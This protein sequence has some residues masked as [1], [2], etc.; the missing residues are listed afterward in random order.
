MDDADFMHIALGLAEKGRGFTSPNPMVGAVVVSDNRIVG[1]G[2]HQ[3]AGGPHAEIN[4]LA[5]AAE[6]ARGATLYVTL[7]PCNHT[8]R[9]GPC[10]AKIISAGIRKVVVAMQDLNPDVCGGGIA[11]LRSHGIEVV[12]GVGEPA[13]RRLN[14]SFVKFITT[15]RPFVIVKCAAT[16]DGR[17]ATHTGDSKWVSGPQARAYVHRLRHSTDA[18]MVGVDTIKADDPQLTARLADGQGKDPQRI[19]LDTHLSI[20]LEA[21]V[22]SSTS[23][24][25]TY[26]VCQQGIDPARRGAVEKKGARVIECELQQGRIDLARLMERL[27]AMQITSLLIE[28]GG[29]VIGSALAAGVVDKILFFYAPKILGGDD[30]VPMARGIGPAA[31]QESIP[32]KQMQIQRFGPDLMIEGYIGAPGAGRDGG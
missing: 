16:L 28:G 19:I 11:F 12:T 3:F 29:R 21:R 23:E 32:V 2:Y 20:P 7:E 24:A 14:E 30:G 6:R 8:G 10:T 5:Q 17:I 18:I 15:K 22:L 13:A 31:M 26:L 1:Q 4:A 9:T 25:A 27:G